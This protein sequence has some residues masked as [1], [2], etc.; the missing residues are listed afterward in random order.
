MRRRR[1]G[2][3]LRLVYT[4]G[5]GIAMSPVTEFTGE[6][7]PVFF[8]K[9]IPADGEIP[10]QAVDNEG[11]PELLVTNPRIYYGENTI[12]YVIA[13]T[14][15]E[16]VDYQTES[17]E[18]FR[19]NYSGHGGVRLSSIVRRMAYAWQF[20]DVNILISGQIT[21]DSRLQYRRAIQERVYI[22]SLRS[23]CST[24]IRI[25][26]LPRAVCSGFRMH[27]HTQTGT[28]IRIRLPAN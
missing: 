27:T 15:Q 3:T 9:D 22:P 4:H 11:P 18:L 17:G 25:S 14:L 26:L 23:C 5:M 28:H 19:T 21:G 7:R 2:R 16:E 10:V 6:G 1:T 24:R 20:A 13:N 8:A 12:D